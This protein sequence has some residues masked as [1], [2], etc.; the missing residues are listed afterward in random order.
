[1]VEVSTDGRQVEVQ[2]GATRI[3]LALEGV[4][5]IDS[6]G[7]GKPP[8]VATPSVPRGG[9]AARELLLL[10]KR[11]DEAEWELDS[12]LDAAFLAEL[13]EVRIVHGAGTGALRKLVREV[14]AGHPLVKSYRP[15]GRGEGGNG[16][17]V[18]QF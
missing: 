17:T 12:Y 15:G 5:R 10:G 3:R 16:V 8:P 6:P 11:A 13:D 1:M 4:T 14:L 9:S 2:A 18:V 7:N